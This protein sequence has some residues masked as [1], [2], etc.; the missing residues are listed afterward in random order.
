M[1][2]L[3]MGSCS[4]QLK[5][6]DLHPDIS[7]LATPRLLPA[8]VKATDFFQITL[9]QKVGNIGSEGS[10]ISNLNSISSSPK[11]RF[12]SFD[13]STEQTHLEKGIDCEGLQFKG[14]SSVFQQ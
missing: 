2:L 8:D 11:N 13:R 12:Y 3:Q 9:K 5:S 1:P 14:C 7:D 6:L 4:A 10:Q